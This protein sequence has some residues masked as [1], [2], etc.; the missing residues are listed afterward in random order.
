VVGRLGRDQIEDYAVRKGQSIALTEK[1][2]AA[3]LDYDPE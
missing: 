2:L 3:N 1:N